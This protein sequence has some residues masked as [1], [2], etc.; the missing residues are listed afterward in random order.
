MSHE[1]LKITIFSQENSQE[2]ESDWLEVE[3]PNGSFVICPGHFDI[4]SLLKP[5][6]EL[7]FK[8]KTGTIAA[9]KVPGGL[10]VAQNGAEVTIIIFNN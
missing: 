7:T 2:F 8:N 9:L 3:A 10:V 5:N 6:G 4:V 1:S